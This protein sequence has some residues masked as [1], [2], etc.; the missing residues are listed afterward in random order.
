MLDLESILKIE[1]GSRKAMM[2]SV[3]REGHVCGICHIGQDAINSRLDLEDMGI[4]KNLHLK[5]D[6]NSYSVPQAPYVM[7]KAQK[8]SFC[9]FLGSVKFP[10]GY[11]S[12]LST[13]VSVDGCNLQ[14][15]KTHD[16]HIL[17]QRILPA[18]VRGIMRKDIYEAI[19]ELGN[20]FQQLCAKTI[21]VDVMHRMKEQIPIILCKLEKIFPPSF[22][23]VML[24]LTVHLPDEAILRG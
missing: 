10:D 13:C 20:F 18:A 3:G 6:E 16:C 14:G 12:N 21:K 5:R 22:F 1:R 9:G 24:H 4:R 19:A 15:L 11:A 17:L 2:A 23:D 7:N 8:I